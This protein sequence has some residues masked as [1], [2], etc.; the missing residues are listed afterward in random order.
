MKN[1]FWHI[2]QPLRFLK[3]SEAEEKA[4]KEMGMVGAK[5]DSRKM[6]KQ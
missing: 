2:S 4:C 6:E 3:A 1:H 5:K